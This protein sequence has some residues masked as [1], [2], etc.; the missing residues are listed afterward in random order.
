MKRYLL[1][2]VVFICGAAVM[3]YELV[4]S[5]VLA[6]YV[7][8]SIFVW[9][10]LIG[11][12]MGSLALGYWL[13]GKAADK[14]PEPAKLAI[15]ILI[16]AVVIGLTAVIKDVFLSW[17]TANN[18][19]IQFNSIISSLVLFSVP[20]VLLGTVSPYAVK[21]RMT[22]LGTSGQTVGNL[23]AISTLGSIVGTFAAGF[24]LIPAFGNTRLFYGL[25]TLLIATSLILFLGKQ[26]AIKISVLI[27]G[28]GLTVTAPSYINPSRLID[29]DTQYNRVWIYDTTDKENTQQPIKVMQTNNESSSAMFLNSDE[30][31]FEYTKYYRLADHFFPGL[32]SA[33][34]LGGAAY[35]YPKDFLAKHPDATIDVV[36]IDPKL[37][38]LA[39][40]YFR[41]PHDS[42][43][44]SYGEDGRTYLNRTTKKY[45]AFLGDAFRSLYSIPYQLTTVKS[46]N[47]IYGLLNDGGVAII[48]VASAITG[49]RGE[50]LRAEYRTFTEVFPQV[51]VLAVRD[52]KKPDVPQNLIIIALK[53]DQQ[54]AWSSDQPELDGYLSHRYPDMV[55]LDIPILTDDHAPVEYL[56]NK[57]I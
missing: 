28:I 21:L 52:P 17:L 45:D 33:L 37:T 36:E 3:I 39:Y 47:K 48:N 14:Q 57:V 9:S 38:E 8:T 4:G 34:M 54:P 53:T 15:I 29:L 18:N 11:V 42:R 23:Y 31:V 46:V 22:S 44:T 12:I 7:G 40:T 24:A 32:K 26:R 41:L 2:T 5:R 56:I 25:A 27:L 19:N 10:S 49:Q 50:F 1:E 35:S 43:L 6:P 16:A 13:G 51:Y 30:L 20:S 55:P